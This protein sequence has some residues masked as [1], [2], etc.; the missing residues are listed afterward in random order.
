MK[1][2]EVIDKL[3]NNNKTWRENMSSIMIQSGGGN[4]ALSVILNE[5]DI[6]ETYQAIDV[7]NIINQGCVKYL[8]T[9]DDEQQIY[10]IMQKFEDPEIQDRE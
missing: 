2:F 9:D 8:L 7:G 4:N 5:N 6:I 10:K 3:H 1:G